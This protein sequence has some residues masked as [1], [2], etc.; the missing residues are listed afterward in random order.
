MDKNTNIL[1]KSWEGLEIP[2][3]LQVGRE[4]FSQEYGKFILEPLHKGFGVTIGNAMRRVL[5][6][7]L[8]GCA[9]YGVKIEG[10]SHEFETIKGIREDVLQIV[11]RDLQVASLVCSKP[12]IF[13]ADISKSRLPSPHIAR[14]AGFDDPV[15][16]NS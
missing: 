13:M 5:L 14:V 2:D 7:S 8:R 4:T 15:D 12:L 10:V 9:A 11:H 6:S 16:A 3:D 1:Q